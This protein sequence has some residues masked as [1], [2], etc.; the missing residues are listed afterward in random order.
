M[1]HL[2]WVAGIT[3]MLAVNA[4]GQVGPAPGEPL[5]LHDGGNVDGWSGVTAMY[6]S[7]LPVGETVT[8]VDYYA[9]D[10]RQFEIES[11]L[12]NFV[13][14]ILRQEG[15]SR[16]NSGGSYS[17]FDVGPVHVTQDIGVNSV[18]WTSMAVPNDGALYHPG[19]LQWQQD[20]D[21]TNGGVVSFANGTGTGMA[22]WDV[23]SSFYFS[24]DIGE[25]EVGYDFLGAAPGHSSAAFEGR[26][27]QVNFNMSACD[28]TCKT[29]T[30]EPPPPPVEGIV[31]TLDLGD[32]GSVDGWSGITAMYNHT[33]EPGD[34]VEAVNYYTADNRAGEVESEL[35]SFVP[36]IVKQEDALEAADGTNDGTGFFS[37]Y[38]VGPVHTP[39]TPGENTFEWGSSA[40]PDDDALYHPAMV[41]WQDTLD[42]S[43]GGFVSFAGSGG[44]G[45]IQFNV[46]TS[47]YPDDLES[48]EPG[49][50]LTGLETHQSVANGRE[51]QF[52][53]VTGAFGGNF[54]PCDVNQDGACDATDFDVLATGVRGGDATAD[55]NDDGSVNSGDLGYWVNDLMNTYFGDSNLDGE[56][57][58][59]DF[60]AAFTAGKYE[61]G[62]SATWA[63][64]DWDG[65]G[66]FDSSDFVAAF[67]DGGFEIGPRGGVAA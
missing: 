11:E 34:T 2:F 53:F 21:N 19:F 66:F 57:N 59:S 23:D 37:I 64:G 38:E 33:L 7:V 10:A 25:V 14:L 61:T 54:D 1:K 52:N 43:N 35:Y 8:S 46:D 29:L 5:D 28:E 56:F 42:D 16:E 20:V 32:G 12:Y 62:N 6:G 26:E 3:M 45:M 50:E 31:G 9:A 15:G 36:I 17:I 55:L 65:S 41:Q 58:S 40:I 60:V 27:Y 67:T 49:F 13:P 18:E 24:D 30:P 39:N 51:Y 22:Q 44:T 63:E 48:L 4:T 47:F